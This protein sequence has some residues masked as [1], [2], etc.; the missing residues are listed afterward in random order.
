MPGPVESDLLDS[1]CARLFTATREG[2]PSADDLVALACLLVDSGR[3]DPPVVEV[4][5]RHP[6]TLTPAELASLAG[7]L[8]IIAP[9]EPGFDLAPE[10]LGALEQAL[11][12][13][14]LDLPPGRVG[15]GAHLVVY[16]DG[17]RIPQWAMV[18][19]GG[20]WISGSNLLPGDADDPLTALVA[21]AD[22]VQESLMELDWTVWPLCAA[23]ARGLHPV[24]LDGAAVWRCSA[25][26]TVARIGEL[27]S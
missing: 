1:L 14:V 25:G 2:F 17:A 20:G 21:V 16:A 18:R 26:H 6:G 24:A 9:F 4:M 3:L 19:L 10:R 13:V 27:R 7:E 23:H 5:E 11:A 15:E 12:T 22:H 8:L